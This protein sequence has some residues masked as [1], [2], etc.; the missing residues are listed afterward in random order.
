[1]DPK[2]EVRATAQEM[3]RLL[4]LLAMCLADRENRRTAMVPALVAMME[5]RERFDRL[6][7]EARNLAPKFAEM[8][9]RFER[10]G[11]LPPR[12]STTKP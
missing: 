9:E 8:L 10:A 3:H 5:V 2:A 4:D 11:L 7:A 12:E 6:P 1:M